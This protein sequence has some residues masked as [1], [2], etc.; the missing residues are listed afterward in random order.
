LVVFAARAAGA[1]NI[2]TAAN[3]PNPT[4]KMKFWPTPLP[5]KHRVRGLDFE[6]RKFI[7]PLVSWK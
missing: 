6:T 7:V 3:N 4:G 2:A 5:R 1:K